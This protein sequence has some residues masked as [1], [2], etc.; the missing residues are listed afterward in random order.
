MLALTQSRFCPKSE[1]FRQFLVVFSGSVVARALLILGMP[2]L[3]RFFLP[4]DIGQWQLFVSL[5]AV[6]APLVSWKYEVAVVLPEEER[7]ASS[8]FWIC[9]LSAVAMAGVWL[10]PFTLYS[11]WLADVI[12]YPWIAR[13][14]WLI[15]ML[16]MLFAI[17][18]CSSFWLTR[19]K[20]FALLAPARMVRSLA[21]IGIPLVAALIFSGNSTQLILGSLVGQLL[22]ALVLMGCVLVKSRQHIWTGFS[23]S[24]IRKVL[25]Q[26]KNYPV[27]VAPYNLLSQ[28]STRMMYFLLAYFATSHVVGL[29][30]MSMQ[31]TFVPVSFIALAISQVLYPRITKQL[32]DGT[33]QP[34]VV[35]LQMLMVIA[36]TPWAVVFAFNA[37]EILDVLLSKRWSET[38]VYAACLT[39]PTLMLLFTAWLNRFYD[40]AGRQRLEF[41]LQSIYSIST[42]VIF[43]LMLR[44]GASTFQVVLAFSV[45]TVIYNMI[46]LA[47]AYRVAGF[48]VRNLLKPLG[49]C[50]VLIAT[51]SIACV[52]CR[53][54][55]SPNLAIVAAVLVVGALQAGLLYV[56]KGVP[57]SWLAKLLRPRIEGSLPTEVAA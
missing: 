8:I 44:S 41:L 30:A 47:F 2:L 31:L 52:V 53:N 22:A 50:V 5:F 55:F 32:E 7:D 20:E 18:Q 9:C 42:V 43:Y 40:V 23:A 13:Y 51:A 48:D 19:H 34:F 17:E 24:N 33:L 39:G 12:N 56:W 3:S 26:Y 15:P 28:I 21:I 11:Q 16:A 4:S 45:T 37:T 38:G 6:V 1:I 57:D 14:G 25:V 35:N 27:F 36:A 46:W 54:S 29:F 10:V 49:C